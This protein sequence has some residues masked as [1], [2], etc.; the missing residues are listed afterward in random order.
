MTSRWMSGRLFPRKPVLALLLSI[1]VALGGCGTI[2]N[3]VERAHQ[4]TFGGVIVDAE[5]ISGSESCLLDQNVK[6]DREYVSVVVPIFGF[7]DMPF[8]LV[9]D[10]VFLP[11]AIIVDL[12][13]SSAD[14]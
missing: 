7:L 12:T 3:W 4:R 9:F 11:V 13:H 14:E 2:G 5:L 10:L 6:H 1:S 8:S